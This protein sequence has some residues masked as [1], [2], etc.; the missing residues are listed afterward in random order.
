MSLQNVP[1]HTWVCVDLLIIGFT[2][3]LVVLACMVVIAPLEQL[4]PA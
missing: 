4:L 3:L 2:I 1:K